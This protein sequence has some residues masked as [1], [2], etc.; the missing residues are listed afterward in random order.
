MVLVDFS[1]WLVI[2]ALVGSK[3]LLVLVELP[4]YLSDPSQLFGL[5]RVGGVFLGGFIAA[6]IAAV[7]LM[8]RYKLRFF[9]TVDVITP[10]LALGHAIGRIGCYFAGCCWGGYCDLPWAMTYSHPDGVHPL[11]TPLGISVHP[12]PIYSMLFNF[13]LFL[14]LAYLYRL[15]PTPGRVLGTYMVFYGLGRYLLEYTRGDQVRGFIFDGLLSTSQAIS[16][17]LI[18]GGLALHGWLFLRR[19]EK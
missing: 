7:I 3:A 18:L 2:W 12:F 19:A 5:V 8:R 16:L 1:I 13:G 17:T 11:G 9:E 6:L 15:R 10:S 14:G 4:R